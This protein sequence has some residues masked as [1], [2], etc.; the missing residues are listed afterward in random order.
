MER[1]RKGIEKSDAWMEPRR[2]RGWVMGSGGGGGM[3]EGGV[4]GGGGCLRP[5]PAVVAF[6]PSFCHSHRLTS[7]LHTQTPVICEKPVLSRLKSGHVRVFTLSGFRFHFR[8]FAMGNT[9][10]SFTSLK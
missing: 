1:K 8:C 2:S 4:G 9:H 7:D 3:R 5:P 10:D 6:V